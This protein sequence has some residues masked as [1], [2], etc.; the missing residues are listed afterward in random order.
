MINKVA[1]KNIHDIPWSD[2]KQKA[3]Q[4]LPKLVFIIFTIL[5]IKVFAELT[6]DLIADNEAQVISAN[7]ILVQGNK[8]QVTRYSLKDVASY[9]LFGNAQKAAPV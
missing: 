8:P 1:I 6:W 5:I 7:K 3:S 4:Y 9:H 2:L